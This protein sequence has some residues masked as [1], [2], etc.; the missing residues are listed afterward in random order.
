MGNLSL[1]L[2]KASSFSCVR[3]RATEYKAWLFFLC[4]LEPMSVY[5]IQVQVSTG[6]VF[7]L[8]WIP[9]AISVLAYLKV[10]RFTEIRSC[11][12]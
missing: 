5:S 3:F 8:R 9:L 7:D 11:W 1:T 12:C 2:L 4:Q 6:F 10:K